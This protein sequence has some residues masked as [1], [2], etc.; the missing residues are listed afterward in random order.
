[1]ETI[2]TCDFLGMSNKPNMGICNQVLRIFTT[3]NG[4]N[5]VMGIYTIV[6]V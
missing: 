6:H 1:M 2:Q 4:E 5:I 3:P